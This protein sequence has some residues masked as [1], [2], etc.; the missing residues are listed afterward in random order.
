MA[1]TTTMLERR[2]DLIGRKPART[3]PQIHVIRGADIERERYEELLALPVADLRVRAAEAIRDEL[4]LDDDRLREAVRTRLATW[5]ELDPE[6]ARI[7]ARAWDQ[8]AG[9]LSPGEARRRIE[10]EANAM[11]HGFNFEDFT[12][13]ARLA[14]WTTSHLGLVQFKSATRRAA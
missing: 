1:P 8:A 6:D 9:A 12:R 7:L 5:V 4:A 11:L 3:T 10:A 13:L 14:P 2:P